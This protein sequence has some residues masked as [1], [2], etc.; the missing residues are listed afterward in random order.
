MPELKNQVTEALYV[1]IME[2]SEIDLKCCSILIWDGNEHPN[3]LTS[4][5]TKIENYTEENVNQEV[6]SKIASLNNLVNHLNTELMATCRS[7][8]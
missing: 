5:S 8:S 2:S 3:L 7:Y 6:E 4:N 1:Y